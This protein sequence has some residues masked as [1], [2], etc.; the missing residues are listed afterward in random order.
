MDCFS[1]HRDRPARLRPPRPLDVSVQVKF[2][3]D[4]LPTAKDPKFRKKL[5]VSCWFALNRAKLKKSE[6]DFWVFVLY[7]FKS[8]TPDYVVIPVGKLRERLR[9]IHGG[10][11]KTIQSYLTVT[12]KNRCWETRDLIDGKADEHRIAD[13]AYKHRT[14]D[15]TK[16]LNEWEPLVRKIGR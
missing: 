15:F 11:S 4:Y 3:K 14:R 6:A 5:R 9:K 2:G 1:R 8:Q 16:W 7:G 12:K 13:G 10:K